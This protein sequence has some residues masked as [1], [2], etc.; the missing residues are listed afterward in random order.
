MT[1]APS[2][3]PTRRLLD[4]LVSNAGAL[5]ALLVAR[6]GTLIG[7]GG[8]C[9]GLD[10]SALAAL[11]AGMHAATREVARLVGERQFSILLQQGSR[12][13]LHVSLVDDA[14]MMVVVFEEQTRIGLVRLEARRAGERLAPLLARPAARVEEALP[15]VARPQFR[16]FALG[17]IDS[18][19]VARPG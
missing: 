12:R 19:F 14:T 4:D 10:T 16:E 17:L 13:H 15:G 5:H 8:D 18:I 1:T 3:S 7:E 11:V 9:A 2:A 6:D